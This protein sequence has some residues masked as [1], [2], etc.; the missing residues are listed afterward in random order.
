M[1]SKF[2]VAAVCSFSLMLAG[3]GTKDKQEDSRVESWQ[4]LNAPGQYY[5]IQAGP[6]WQS[7]QAALA[8]ANTIRPNCPCGI[9]SGPFVN[10]IGPPGVVDNVVG[11]ISQTSLWGYKIDGHC[12]QPSS[13]NS[14]PSRG[15]NGGGGGRGGIG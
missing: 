10:L 13:F 8:I 3:C 6:S 14:G 15:G 11:G 2:L 7:K 4:C 9:F 5:N 12:R 1:G